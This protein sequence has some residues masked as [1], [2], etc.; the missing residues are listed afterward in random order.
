M[1][2]SAFRRMDFTLE[3]LASLLFVWDQT[4]RFQKIMCEMEPVPVEEWNPQVKMCDS[5]PSLF[6]TR[7][8]SLLNLVCKCFHHGHLAQPVVILSRGGWTLEGKLLLNPGLQ[9]VKM[10][11]LYKLPLPCPGILFA[12]TVLSEDRS[13]YRIFWGFG[14]FFISF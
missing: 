12:R 6:A 13:V 5:I 11:G 2:I 7:G 4:Q 14:V 10:L 3:R 1:Y 9:L 8:L